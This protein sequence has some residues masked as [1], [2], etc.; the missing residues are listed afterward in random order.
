M[1]VEISIDKYGHVIKSHSRSSRSRVP[2]MN[3][4][5]TKAKQ[6]AESA[7]FLKMYNC[8]SGTKGYD[9]CLLNFV[10]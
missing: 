1:V 8:S 7:L 10:P 4:S 2:T 6:A 5:K 9:H 3:T